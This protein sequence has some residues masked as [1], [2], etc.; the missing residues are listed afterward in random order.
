MPLG[1]QNP[2]PFRVGPRSSAQD[3]HADLRAAVGERS[4]GNSMAG[5]EGGLEDLEARA[6]SRA[7]ASGA[8]FFDRYAV[9][10][11]PHKMS[12]ALGAWEK[13]LA[14]FSKPTDPDRRAQ[15]AQRFALNIDAAMPALKAGLKAIS[16]NFDIAYL[17]WEYVSFVMHGSRDFEGLPGTGAAPYAVG[18]AAGRKSTRWPSGHTDDMT[19]WVKYKVVPPAS[20]IPRDHLDAAA[21]FLNSTLPADEGFS[22]ANSA[23]GPDGFGFYLDGGPDGT[24]LMDQTSFG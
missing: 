1:W 16:P 6:V 11:I 20:E 15:I 22:I 13:V 24:S 18:Q 10:A 21:A 14:V 3:I 8:T 17:P 4:A 9:Q 12:L 23:D 5:P 7:L 19:V 2:L